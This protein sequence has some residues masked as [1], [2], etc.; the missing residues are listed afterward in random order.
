MISWVFFD[1]G[2]TLL[3]DGPVHD[4]INRKLVELLAARGQ[5][6]SMEELLE[7][8]DVLLAR[9]ERPLFRAVA[10]SFTRD[11]AVA[12]A[13]RKETMASV[14]DLVNET[15]RAY[16]EARE[17]LEAASAHANLGVIANQL[18]GARE[19]MTRDGLDPFFRIV[20]LSEVLGVS[21]PDPAIFEAALRE[22]GCRPSEAVMVGDRID[23]DIEPAKAL[24]FR[25]VR[26]R[27]GVFRH[28]FPLRPAQRPD[29]EVASL[30][31][32]PHAL[33]KLAR[34]E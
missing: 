5:T 26:V 34:A 9:Q 15:Q 7:V 20:L 1:L 33:E 12:E 6:V 13:I 25:T 27:S 23:N 2:G 22:A 28:Q 8:R 16:P 24:G 11:P 3:D 29:V 21:K 18:R 19:V 31:E 10:L 14:S 30:R 4:L 32:V 17:V